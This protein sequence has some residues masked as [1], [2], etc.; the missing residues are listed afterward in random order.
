MNKKNQT[1]KQTVSLAAAARTASPTHSVS[2]ILYIGIGRVRRTCCSRFPVTWNNNGI[3]TNV[4]KESKTDKG[5][6]QKDCPRQL[7]LPASETIKLATRV[8]IPV[9]PRHLEDLLCSSKLVIKAMFGL[10]VFVNTF[11]VLL[12]LILKIYLFRFMCFLEQGCIS[13]FL[14]LFPLLYQWYYF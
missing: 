12:F 9:E 1:N 13:F 3:Y 2:F 4:M 10:T 5:R 6:N 8:R 11:L 7:R 14:I